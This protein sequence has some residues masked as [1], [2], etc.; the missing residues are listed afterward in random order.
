L[1][2]KKKK[3]VLKPEVQEK[4]QLALAKWRAEKVAAKAAGPKAYAK[5]L[6]E[7]DLK[8]KLKK[9][10]PMQAIKNFCLYCVGDKREDVTNCTARQ[11]PLYIY[12]PYQKGEE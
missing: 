7:N 8:R 10:T 6:E 1:P 11:C 12:R 2:L 5:W 4:G 3:R 9:T